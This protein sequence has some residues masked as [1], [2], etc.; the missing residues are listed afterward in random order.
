MTTSC[1]AV[2]RQGGAAL[3]QGDACQLG[4]VGER[5][6]A[7]ADA[8][9]RDGDALQIAAVP[10]GAFVDGL[11][12]TYAP[13]AANPELHRS[14]TR[15]RPTLVILDEIH[16]GG[17]ALSW[18]DALREAFTPARRRLLPTICVRWH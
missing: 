1:G 11:C 14:R 7:D 5:L 17:D 4:A 18:G 12:V 10:E 8:V 2:L 16:H 6:F 15:R 13:G 3:R 9:P